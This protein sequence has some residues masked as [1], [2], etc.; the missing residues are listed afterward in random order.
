MYIK[1]PQQAITRPHY[2]APFPPCPPY[3]T[4]AQQQMQQRFGNVVINS[5]AQTG[6]A[7]PNVYHH[8]RSPVQLTV[9]GQPYL[10]IA[11]QSYSS[12][13]CQ[14]NYHYNNNKYK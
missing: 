12:P 3:W 1:S 4:P 5:Y 6:T 10:T 8:E 9:D 13:L 2:A 14:S 7:P 11:S